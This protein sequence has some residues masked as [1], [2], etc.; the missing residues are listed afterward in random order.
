MCQAACYWSQIKEIYYACNCKEAQDHGLFR[1]GEV[2]KMFESP[3]EER[4]YSM[5]Q[6]D[7]E[8]K[9]EAYIVFA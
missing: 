9:F 4:S 6:I 3:L 5:K 8:D 7:V 2:D 1:A